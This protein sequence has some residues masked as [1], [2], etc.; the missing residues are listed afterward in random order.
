MPVSAG[1]ACCGAGIAD[2]TLY[3]RWSSHSSGSNVASRRSG[4]DCIALQ[5]CFSFFLPY[6]L[7][8]FFPFN[9][10]L[11]RYRSFASVDF[12]TYAA[13]VNND[14]EPSARFGLPK[15]GQPLREIV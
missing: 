14:W 1:A 8:N 9:C 15:Q 2:V 4:V 7:L 13:N 6:C 3:W 5:T 10:S 11:F 12:L